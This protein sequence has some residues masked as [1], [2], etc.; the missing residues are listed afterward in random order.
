MDLC[1]LDIFAVAVWH[2]RADM[3]YVQVMLYILIPPVKNI[4]E[5]FASINSGQIPRMFF[6]FTYLF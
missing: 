4:H 6:C 1:V 3:F 2:K 5:L